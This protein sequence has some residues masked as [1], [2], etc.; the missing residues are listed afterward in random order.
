MSGLKFLVSILSG[1][2]AVRRR[3]ERGRLGLGNLLLQALIPLVFVLFCHPSWSSTI[4]L[5]EALGL[6]LWQ[7]EVLSGVKPNREIL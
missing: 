1:P 6:C 7:S 2:T 3:L 4:L 5:L